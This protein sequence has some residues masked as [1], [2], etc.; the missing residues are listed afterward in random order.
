MK[1]PDLRDT[2]SKEK[3]IQFESQ[4][5]DKYYT[6]LQEHMPDSFFEEINPEYYTLIA[7]YLM[8]FP[9]QDYFCKVELKE[10]AFVL[11]LDSP[12]VDMN[13]LRNFNLYG[14]KNYK[15]FLSNSAPPFPNVKQRLRIAIIHFTSVDEGASKAQD[16]SLSTPQDLDRVHSQI[17][18]L[19]PEFT[20]ESLKNLIYSMDPLFLR[21]L[22]TERLTL[23]LSM[24]F[25]AW[26]RDYCQYEVRRQDD[27]KKKVAGTPSLQIVFAWRSVP[28]YRF[29][30]RLAKLMYRHNL[31]MVHVNATYIDPYKPHSIL[32]MSVGLHGITGKAAWEE[33]DIDDFLRELVTL[34]YFPDGDEIEKSFVKTRL[35]RGNL[36]NFLRAMISFI[37]QTLVHIDPNAYTPFRIEEGLCRHPK[38]TLQICRIFELKFHFEHADKKKYSQE[39]EDLLLQIDHLDTGNE[40]TDKRHKNILKQAAYFIDFCLKTNFY[41]NNKSALSFR[42]NP[43]YLDFVPY[44]REALFP[45]LPYAI[46]FVHGMHFIGFHIRFKDL[47][48]G[49]L[50]TVFPQHHDQT[51]AERNQ[52]FIECYNL[53]YTQQKKNKDIPEGGAKG[54]IFLE[55]YSHL[56]SEIEIYRKELTVAG[57][58]KDTIAATLQV[59]EQEQK[60]QYLYQTQRSFIYNLVTLVNCHDDGTLRAKN[61]VDYWKRPEYIY[62]GPDENMHNTM[63]KWIAAYSEKCNYKPGVAFISSKPSIGIN[64]KEYGVTSFGVN[65]YMREVLHF[66]GIDP[67]KDP[68]SV[69]ISGGP[70][71]DVAGNQILNLKR[72]FPKTAKLLAITDV[73]GTI[74]D[75]EGLD[76]DAL[77]TLFHQSKPIAAYPVKKLSDQGFL[78]NLQVKK[79]ETTYTQKTLCHR[80][81]KGKLKEDWLPGS[82]MNH[83]FRHNLH[84]TKADIFIPAGGRPRTLNQRNYTDFLDTNGEPTA[85]AIVEGANLYLTPSARRALEKIG[86][87]IIKDSSANKG[88]V[89]CSSMEVLFGLTMTS[90]EFLAHKETLMQQTLQIIEE[91]ARDE[92]QLLLKTHA[93]TKHYLTDISEQ[94]SER[95]NFYTFQLLDYLE[96]ALLPSHPEDPLI[97]ALLNFC[98]PLLAEEYRN[99]ILQKVPV[100]HKKAIIA[101]YLA[102]RLVYKKSLLWSPSVVDVL[103]LIATDPI[104]NPSQ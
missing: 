103:P 6:W 13:I 86:V 20:K 97:K 56:L 65:V 59:F 34:K 71:G 95:I 75:P 61:V 32:M 70:D 10:T 23:A 43:R 16:A 3:A 9:L 26:T 85:R 94:I 1:R 14:I 62:L 67:E 84:Q 49:G 83:L 58:D 2:A 4:Q 72:Y 91:K 19:M 92:A 98:P 73:S 101:C 21:S 41:R 57:K 80:K 31:C 77:A 18:Q 37:H 87:I 44:D 46:F 25:R 24:F 45:E 78:L 79:A 60:E 39:K 81:E 99:Q 88:G 74:F 33:T 11:A 5:F 36:G 102:S 63:I 53:A 69:K 55:P 47:A 54:V 52:V 22:S 50:R 29:L 35:I 7:H 64:H 48:R 38:L 40:E 15:T 42:L 51:V 27:W 17:Q 104:I 66:L 93:E 89:I 82:Q 30:F 12:E 96:K 100:I 68:F 90:E 8:G 28:K 76:L